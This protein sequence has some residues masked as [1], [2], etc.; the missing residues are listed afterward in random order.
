[1]KFFFFLPREKQ[2]T[3][4]TLFE[5]F[6]PASFKTRSSG[7]KDLDCSDSPPEG[8]SPIVFHPFFYGDKRVVTIKIVG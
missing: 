6:L 7:N 5:M 8:F 2:G 4:G 3:Q 1:L